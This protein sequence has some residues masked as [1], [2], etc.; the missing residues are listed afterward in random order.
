MNCLLWV[1]FL[2]ALVGCLELLPQIK[3][4]ALEIYIANLVV[5]IILNCL[6]G[7]QLLEPYLSINL[8]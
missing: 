8:I 2:I 4:H 6:S 7:F 5:Y 3:T 1:V